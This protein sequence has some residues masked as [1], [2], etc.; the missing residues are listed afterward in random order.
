MMKILVVSLALVMGVSALSI[1]GIMV[2]DVNPGKRD[3]M[4]PEETKVYSQAKAA[5]AMRS[6]KERAAEKERLAV[7][8]D[9]KLVNKA[10]K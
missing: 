3:V 9:I 8:G 5:E 2:D 1:N 6:P 10:K 7:D 4:I